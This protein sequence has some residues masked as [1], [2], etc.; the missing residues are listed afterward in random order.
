MNLDP[1]DQYTEEE[2]WRALES[3]HLKEFAVS[4]AGG[5]EHMVSEGGENLRSFCKPFLTYSLLCVMDS[6]HMLH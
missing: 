1:F 5:L 3:A 2:V 6:V 4:L